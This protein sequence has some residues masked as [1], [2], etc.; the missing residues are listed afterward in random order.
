MKKIALIL[1]FCLILIPF[2]CDAQQIMI[3]KKKA[4]GCSG[5][6]G[7][8]TDSE[9]GIGEGSTSSCIVKQITG[10]CNGNTA[11]I[12][13]RMS[14]F[15]SSTNHRYSYVIYSDNEGEPNSLLGHVHGTSSDNSGPADQVEN[16][17][18]ETG[19]TTIWVGVCMETN[20]MVMYTSTTGGVARAGYNCSFTYDAPPATWNTGCTNDN[21]YNAYNFEIAV[22]F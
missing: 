12:T 22:T 6:Y 17:V 5:T 19:A 21:D 10:V 9:T 15:G 3:T 2:I 1:L 13:A 4:A 11:S 20:V 7:N 14:Y 18:E 16:I 8:T